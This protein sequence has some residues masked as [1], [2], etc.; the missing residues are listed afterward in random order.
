MMPK[1][2]LLGATVKTYSFL[3][4]RK[5]YVFSTGVEQEV[6]TVV[7]LILKGKK[8]RKG[9]SLFLVKDLPEIIIPAAPQK[10]EHPVLEQNVIMPRQQRF[11]QWH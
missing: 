3:Y 4:G 1:V 10:P 9:K 7:A 11:G 6:P 5:E 8:N 2:T